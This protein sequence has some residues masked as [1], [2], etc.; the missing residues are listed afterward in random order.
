MTTA[1]TG[2]RTILVTG[3]TGRQGGAVIDALLDAGGSGWQ[4]RALTRDATSE[5]AQELLKRGVEVVT[6]DQ[7]DVPSLDRAVAGVHGVFSIQLAM[8]FEAENRQARNLADAAKRAGVSHIVATL[9]AGA[10]ME[11]T[12][13]ERFASKRRIADYLKDLGLPVTILRPTGFMENFLES[14]RQI[15]AGTLTGVTA[16]ET[17][18]W[19]IAVGDIGAFAAAAFA[20]PSDFIGAEIDLAGDELSGS[21]LAEVFSRVIGRTVEYRQPPHEEMEQTFPAER[22]ALYDWYDRVG[23]RLDVAD[24]RAR[25]P[26][27]ALMTLEDWLRSPA[28]ASATVDTKGLTMPRPPK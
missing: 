14:R 1:P 11:G 10:G 5:K 20:A 24:L 3:A 13:L 4:A 12:D 7:E 9:A 6:G 15:L 25:W 28:W 18:N 8:D 21:E 22:V 16:A 17:V 23:Y 2:Q 27:P 26:K 19:Y